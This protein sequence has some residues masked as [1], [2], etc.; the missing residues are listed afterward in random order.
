LL[1][2]L[3]FDRKEGSNYFKTLVAYTECTEKCVFTSTELDRHE[4][5][6]DDTI[7]CTQRHLAHLIY[8]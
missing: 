7:Y 5:L 4:K 8:L 3:S 6:A 2:K 1:R